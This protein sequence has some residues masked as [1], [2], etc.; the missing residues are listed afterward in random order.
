M[1]QVSTGTWVVIAWAVGFIQA[2]AQILAGN[3]LVDR[4]LR[5]R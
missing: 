3:W 5:R 1:K 4:Q 2:T